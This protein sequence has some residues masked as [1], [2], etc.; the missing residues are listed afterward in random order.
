MGSF[1]LTAHLYVA[2]VQDTLVNAKEDGA[3][4]ASARV[5]FEVGFRFPAKHMCM[6]GRGSTAYVDC[7]KGDSAITYNEYECCLIRTPPSSPCNRFCRRLL[8]IVGWTTSK[9][10]RSEG[11]CR[12]EEFKA[13]NGACAVRKL[14]S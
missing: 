10:W 6:V 3:S 8:C 2:L 5:S 13:P 12:K 14:L 1:R 11:V 7:I 9:G 4:T